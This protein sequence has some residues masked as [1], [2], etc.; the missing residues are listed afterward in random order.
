MSDRPAYDASDIHRSADVDRVR[1][2]QIAA[3]IAHTRQALIPF[4]NVI[5][6]YADSARDEARRLDLPELGPDLDRIL[7]CAEALL[8][9]VERVCESSNGPSSQ[10]EED[11]AALQQRL[12]HDLRNSLG[13]ITGYGE[14]LLEAAEDIGQSILCRD[15][16]A[17]L[18]KSEELLASLDT[19]VDLSSNET[20]QD[21]RQAEPASSSTL[22]FLCNQSSSQDEE[23]SQEKG[24]IL[25]VDDNVN[26]RDLLARRLRSEGH[27]PIEAESGGRA[28]EMVQAEDI[29]LILLD[30][31]MPDMNGL[32]VLQ[33]LKQ[34][35]RLRT[36]PVIMISGLR[37]TE[38]L[39]RCIEAGAEDY[40]PKPWN[41]ILLRA[42]VGACLEKKRLHDQEMMHLAE[43]ELQRQ[44]LE[45]KQQ[46][47]DQELKIAR[48]L[49]AAILP[50]DFSDFPKESIAT[51]MRPAYEMG[52]DFYDVFRI[53]EGRV[54]FVIGDVS[55]KGVAAAFFMAVTRTMVRN[56]AMSGMTPA[57][58][59]AEVNDALCR[60]N[61]AEMFVT[62]FYGELDERSG[63]MTCINAGHCE[64]ILA[65]AASGLRLLK[66]AGNLPLGVLPE[67][68]FRETAVVLAEN[69][70]LFLYTD[71]VT[72]A[73]DRQGNLYDVP[74]LLKVVESHAGGPPADMITAVLG[75]IEA[76]ADGTL[77]SDDITC[78]AVRRNSR[79]EVHDLTA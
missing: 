44:R 49:Q 75:S 2:E 55:G 40:L 1:D 65:S 35:Q 33:R 30:L 6:G 73:F 11:P 18:A 68:S 66:H 67:L 13:A 19:I 27:Q 61:P 52:G 54:G 41:P 72:E 31:M 28:L 53:A 34:D 69:E 7:A 77:Q 58:C 14:M 24:T 36:I 5:S 46:R 4:V 37:E 50:T 22:D 26:S 42:R 78:L 9:T 20:G 47:I 3:R 21:R 29:D 57:R 60:E 64:P 16:R 76:F 51:L 63:S 38:S 62:V 70:T 32:Q 48:D 74:R 59:I 12:R 17:L 23:R 8:A 39:I 25:V 45:E 56:V 15:L 10:A 79:A 71:G 43:I